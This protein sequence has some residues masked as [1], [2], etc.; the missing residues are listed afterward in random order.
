VAGFPLA[1]TSYRLDSTY[2]A[3]P[4]IHLPGAGARLAAAEDITR[5]AVEDK[6]LPGVRRLLRR[7]P[8]GASLGDSK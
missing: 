4:E 8:S 6:V 2:C 7:K 3:N 5:E 1:F